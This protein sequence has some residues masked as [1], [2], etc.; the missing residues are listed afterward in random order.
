MLDRPSA[1]AMKVISDSALIT[2]Q[3]HIDTVPYL[4]NGTPL[5]LMLWHTRL[6]AGLDRAH[7]IRQF[8]AVSGIAR[9]NP[10]NSGIV[11]K[12]EVNWIALSI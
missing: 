8:K 5:P 11:G 1:K 7:K 12:Y 2:S 10:G 6:Q 3:C 4:H 9:H